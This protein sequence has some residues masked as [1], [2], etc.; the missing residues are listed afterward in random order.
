[1]D[2][3]EDWKINKFGVQENDLGCRQIFGSYEGVIGIYQKR[4]Y[5][6]FVKVEKKGELRMEFWNILLFGVWESERI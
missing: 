2:I 4:L 5:G 3:Y 1:M 6:K